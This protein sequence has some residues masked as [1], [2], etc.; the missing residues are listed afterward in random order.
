MEEER[1]GSQS[2]I[3]RRECYLKPNE[4]VQGKGM[5]LLLRGQVEWEPR[6]YQ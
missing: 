4:K 1:S 2:I 3:I 6:A 5:E